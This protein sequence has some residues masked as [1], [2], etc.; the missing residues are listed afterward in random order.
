MV[1]AVL[2]VYIG[3]MRPY[4]RD[5]LSKCRVPGHGVRCVCSEEIGRDLNKKRSRY[6]SLKEILED[7]YFSR[8]GRSALVLR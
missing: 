2:R 4:G 6:L 5:R 8:L 1:F 7:P 3:F